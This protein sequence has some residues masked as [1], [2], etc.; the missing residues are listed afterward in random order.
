MGNVLGYGHS[1]E[2][3]ESIKRYVVTLVWSP[4]RRSVTERSALEGQPVQIA[5]VLADPEYGFLDVQKIGNFRTAL[6]IPLLREGAPIVADVDALTGKTVQ[7]QAD[8]TGSYLRR[9]GGDRQENVRL[10]DEI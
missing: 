3:H 5:D 6:G 1:K 9:S 2:E 7:R 4:G 8:R 10:F